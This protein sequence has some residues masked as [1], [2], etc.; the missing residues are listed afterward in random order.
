MYVWFLPKRLQCSGD[1]TEFSHACMTALFRSKK[2]DDL[3]RINVRRNDK[4]STIY[5]SVMMVGSDTFGN[6]IFQRGLQN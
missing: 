1:L 5:S 2:T 4:T 3:T 6:P